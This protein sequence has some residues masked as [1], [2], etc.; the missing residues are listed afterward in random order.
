M[1]NNTDFGSNF[2]KYLEEMIPKEH[3]DYKELQYSDEIVVQVWSHDD[4]AGAFELYAIVPHD[5]VDEEYVGRNVN[6]L[7]PEIT[8]VSDFYDDI[9]TLVTEVTG[10]E[11]E[12]V[13][14]LLEV[15]DDGS[16]ERDG[17]CYCTH[18]LTTE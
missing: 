6:Q 16:W 17:S 10:K 13:F 9:E 4:G 1:G 2:K 8:G 11:F 14:H 3:D 5:S 7:S 12:I 18:K 15:V